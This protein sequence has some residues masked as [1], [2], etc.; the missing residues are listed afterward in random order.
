MTS[1]AREV[2]RDP[3]RRRGRLR[4]LGLARHCAVERHLAIED[5][6]HDVVRVDE[7]I[8]D[9]LLVHR[10]PDVAVHLALLSALPTGQ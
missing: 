6:D 8:G 7:R 4:A 3:P 5:V 2:A 1:P 9:Q 10:R